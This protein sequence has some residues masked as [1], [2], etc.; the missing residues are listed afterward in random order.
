MPRLIY[1]PTPTGGGYDTDAEAY[2]TAVEGTGVTLS[3]TQKDAYNAFVVS[4]KGS[5]FYTKFKAIY[6]FIGATAASHAINAFSPGTYNITWTGTVTHDSN[7]PKG[8][9]TTG[10]GNTGLTPSSVFSSNDIFVGLY[11]FT[12]YGPEQSGSDWKSD[13]GC[14]G[15]GTGTIDISINRNYIDGLRI[16]INGSPTNYANLIENTKGCFIMKRNSGYVSSFRKGY[17]YLYRSSTAT[18]APNVNLYILARNENGSVSG[19]SKRG[20]SFAA[21]GEGLTDAEATLLDGYITTLQNSLSRL[22]ADDEAIGFTGDSI[23]ARM[24]TDRDASTLYVNPPFVCSNNVETSR[25]VNVWRLNCGVD[26]T[27]TLS[28]SPTDSGTSYN[29]VSLYTDSVRRYKAAGA[30][31][32]MIMLGTN[33]GA[34]GATSPATFNTR[35]SALAAA[36]VAEGFKVVLNYTPFIVRQGSALCPYTNN[37]GETV[38]NG[39]Y[40][41]TSDAMVTNLMDYQDEIDTIVNGTTILQGDTT[42]WSYFE[43][44]YTELKDGVHMTYDGKVSLGGM[45]SSA[46]ISLFPTA[47]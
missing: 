2:F 7:G 31:V 28:W 47:P 37:D 14:V 9:G 19:R 17:R 12:Q 38:S 11:S 43:T 25:G 42:A 23:T 24:L 1:I 4:C 3:S 15:S 6:P 33:D 22:I 20:L 10:Y 26:G 27:S 35:L 36:Y 46:Y 16:G 40:Q 8:D 39:F 32:V 45:W 44:N 21:F 34:G 18:T 5:S 13:C 29:G 30:K 41:Y